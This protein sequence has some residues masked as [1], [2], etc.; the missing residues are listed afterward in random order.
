MKK[1]AILLLGVTFCISTSFADDTTPKGAT[2][3]FTV[4]VDSH[5]KI[6]VE[7]KE[8]AV[9]AN[10]ESKP[11]HLVGSNPATWT[12]GYLSIPGYK[13]CLNVVNLRGWDGYCMPKTKNDK[14]E[15]DS[16]KKLQEMKL[17]PCSANSK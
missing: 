3:T 4:P 10:D 9:Q 7:K 1:I 6:D 14:C 11:R 13:K 2:V 15:K 16:W 12:P 5:V 17:M 8:D